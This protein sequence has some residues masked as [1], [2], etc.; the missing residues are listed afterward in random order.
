MTL[1]LLQKL[2]VP[3]RYLFPCVSRRF[4]ASRKSRDRSRAAARL[5]TVPAGE[6]PAGGGCPAT[7]VVISGGEKGGQLAGSPDVNVSG[8]DRE[9]SNLAGCSGSPEMV[10]HGVLEDD[11]PRRNRQRKPGWRRRHRSKPGPRHRST[12]HEIAAGR[13]RDA[14]VRRFGFDLSRPHDST[15][16]ADRPLHPG[17]PVPVFRNAAYT[18]VPSALPLSPASPLAAWSTSESACFF[19]LCAC[20]CSWP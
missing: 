20:D 7:T 3:T 1:R 15:R 6:S 10:P 8:S 19:H 12:R 18:M 2:R 17:D 11:M 16:G 13:G 9:A 14:T 5:V 4:T